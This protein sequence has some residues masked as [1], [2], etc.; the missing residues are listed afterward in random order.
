MT[1][2]L[3]LLALLAPAAPAAGPLTPP[4]SHTTAMP[5]YWWRSFPGAAEQARAVRAFVA[6]LLNDCPVL[7]DVLLSAD[8]LAVNAVR[9]TKSGQGGGSFTVTVQCSADLVA[10]S[11]TDQGGPDEPA[12]RDSDPLA[13][14]GRGLRTVS[15]TAAA[16]GWHGNDT[17]RTVTAVFTIPPPPDS[18]PPA[19]TL[20]VAAGPGIRGA[21][22]WSA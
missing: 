7:D 21:G 22:E 10:I 6:C 8:E 13:E 1:D 3:T 12:A 16:W 18:V 4:P 20:G 14:S 9:H 11:V 5:L 19:T 15:R 2:S 17:G